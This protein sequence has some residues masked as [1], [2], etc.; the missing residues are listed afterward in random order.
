MY[1]R[2]K[3]AFFFRVNDREFL[4]LYVKWEALCHGY[5]HEFGGMD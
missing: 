5:L 2:H 1:L 3:P 4:T